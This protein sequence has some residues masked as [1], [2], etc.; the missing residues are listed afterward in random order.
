A[1]T[2]PVTVFNPTPAGG[3]STAVDFTV[4]N[5]QPVVSGVSPANI[6]VGGVAFSLTIDGTGFVSGSVVRSG[7]SDRTTAFVSSTQLTAQI[8][9]ANISTVGALAVTVHNPIPGGGVSNSVNLTVDPPAPG[10]RALRAVD[11]IANPGT[12]VNVSIEIVSQGDE[13][14]LGFSL[15]F[16]PTQLI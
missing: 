4:N 11:V 16:D 15:S 13:N 12:T 1:G 5:T 14:S 6:T 9:V 10:A 8:S 7:G 2:F 3:T